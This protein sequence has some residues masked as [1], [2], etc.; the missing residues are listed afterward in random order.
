[1]TQFG[2]SVDI[3]DPRASKEEVKIQFGIGLIDIISLQTGKP[4]NAIILAVAHN[5]FI[6][7]DLRKLIT[8]ATVVFD[9]KA[10]LDRAIVDGRL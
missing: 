2:L 10:V 6:S 3:C 7:F 8:P 4:Y 1:M 9:T 5:E